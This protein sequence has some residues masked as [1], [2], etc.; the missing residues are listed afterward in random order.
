MIS[1]RKIQTDDAAMLA[2]DKLRVAAGLKPRGTYAI[3]ELE[4]EIAA[5][6][7]DVLRPAAG[8]LA[9]LVA[10]LARRY[11][12]VV[13]ASI[14]RGANENFLTDWELRNWLAPRF[15]G[16]ELEGKI[17]GCLLVMRLAESKR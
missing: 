10:T 16:R 6:R 12:L 14:A 3:G 17:K 5:D 11:G 9:R 4:A 13:S 7:R 8:P 15:A 1:A 2:A